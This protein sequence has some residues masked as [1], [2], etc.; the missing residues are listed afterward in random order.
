M[1]KMDPLN[2]VSHNLVVYKNV[3][4]NVKRELTVI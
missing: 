1:V 4:Y 2:V 3:I